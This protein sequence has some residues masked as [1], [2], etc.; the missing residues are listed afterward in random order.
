MELF[1][2][3]EIVHVFSSMQGTHSASLI[4]QWSL[5]LTS[6]DIKTHAGTMN[7]LTAATA[8]HD[9][10]SR[11]DRKLR[12]RGIKGSVSLALLCWLIFEVPN[13]SLH[14]RFNTVA[15]HSCCASCHSFVSGHIIATAR[16]RSEV[17]HTSLLRS[18]TFRLLDVHNGRR[19]SAATI[20][21]CCT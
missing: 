9:A 4:R 20:V 5:S 18:S 1:E 21:Q 17:L 2:A 8:L 12:S 19:T 15:H 3:L 6:R 14:T 10:C 13:R 7:L 11:D 16:T